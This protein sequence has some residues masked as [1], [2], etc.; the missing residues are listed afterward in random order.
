MCRLHF[1]RILRGG[2]VPIKEVLHSCADKPSD[3]HRKSYRNCPSSWTKPKYHQGFLQP[4]V[5]QNDFSV[6]Q[7]DRTL[8]LFDFCCW[9]PE[10][11]GWL[12]RNVDFADWGGRSSIIPPTSECLWRTSLKEENQRVQLPYF[13]SN[14]KG[15]VNLTFWVVFRFPILIAQWTGNRMRNKNFLDREWWKL[16]FH[17]E[18]YQNLWGTGL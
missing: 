18:K 10:T 1:D 6:A 15:F 16:F 8:P 12:K 4:S 5:G 17:Y 9:I 3:L 11:S 2:I 14:Y 13:Y 7:N